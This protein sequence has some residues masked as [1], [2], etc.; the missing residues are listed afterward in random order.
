MQE[1]LIQILYIMRKLMEVQIIDGSRL[2][3]GER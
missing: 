3:D 2:L 1:W